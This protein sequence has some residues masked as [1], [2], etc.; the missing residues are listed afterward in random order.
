M[1]FNQ[2]KWQRLQEE[3]TNANA[4]V[5][6]LGDKR[7]NA[8]SRLNKLEIEANNA[9]AKV[10]RELE[11]LLRETSSEHDELLAAEGRAQLEWERLAA[12]V[13]RCK[14]FLQSKGIHSDSS[15][16]QVVNP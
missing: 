5:C 16:I 7:R 6:T 4:A 9:G 15:T 3:A 11:R 1:Q 8:K 12:I 14:N 13:A 2:A 10:S